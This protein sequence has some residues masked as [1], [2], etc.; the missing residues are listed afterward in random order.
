M[1][2]SQRISAVW[3]IPVAKSKTPVPPALPP[4]ASN[5]VMDR[6]QDPLM[7]ALRALEELADE[8]RSKDPE[9]ALVAKRVAE[10]AMVQL[11][12]LR[13]GSALTTPAETKVLRDACN[14]LH[15]TYARFLKTLIE[16]WGGPV[17]KGAD[18]RKVAMNFALAL[19]TQSPPSVRDQIKTLACVERVDQVA[20]LL[21]TFAPKPSKRGRKAG[22]TP[23]RRWHTIAVD[24]FIL[25]GVEPERMTALERRRL[26]AKIRHHA[27]S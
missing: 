8:A 27:K 6:R 23:E 13:T 20:A 26:S 2:A 3:G 4:G 1:V 10:S 25:A 19:A 14:R 18:P 9:L 17:K 15:R 5:G 7:R 22:T 12:A 24:L 21:A 16:R 11:Q